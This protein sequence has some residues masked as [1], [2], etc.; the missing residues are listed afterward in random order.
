MYRWNA[1]RDRYAWAETSSGD[2]ET[3]VISV[4]RAGAAEPHVRIH[5]GFIDGYLVAVPELALLDR[6]REISASGI[7]L[8]NSEAFRELVPSGRYLDFSA[9][10]FT[11]LGGVVGDVLRTASLTTEQRSLSA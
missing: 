8:A 7:N 3:F 4:T 6:A 2:H 9:V 1:A 11:R 10:A 5:Y